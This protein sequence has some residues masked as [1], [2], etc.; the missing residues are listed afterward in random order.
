MDPSLKLYRHLVFQC[1]FGA[2]KLTQQP[3]VD[4]DAV[5]F[6]VIYRH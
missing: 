2:G 3:N 6:S 5:F 4:R 1:V